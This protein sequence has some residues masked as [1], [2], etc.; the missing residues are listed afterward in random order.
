MVV[1]RQTVGMKPLGVDQSLGRQAFSEY[2]QLQAE[3]RGVILRVGN[4]NTIAVSQLSFFFRPDYY[5][6]FV[7]PLLGGNNSRK[8][9]PHGVVLIR[10]GRDSVVPEGHEE[11][12][13]HNWLVGYIEQVALFV[14]GKINRYQ[15]YRT[16][17]RLN[18]S[19]FNE[20]RKR[21]IKK[22]SLARSVADIH[23]LNS[24]N[25]ARKNRNR[26]SFLN[27]P[28]PFRGQYLFQRV[29]KEKIVIAHIVLL[30][31]RDFRF[32]QDSN[33]KYELP[34]AGIDTWYIMVYYHI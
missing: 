31:Q 11:V 28:W 18:R 14:R 34:Q 8:I 33:S 23:K 20:N 12:R 9:D 19:A 2:V 6:H 22:R 10:L 24:R 32:K 15:F 13:K 26:F 29:G 21:G 5:L 3:F 25:A 4:R 16:Q 30:F 27:G 17:Y 1:A 7:F